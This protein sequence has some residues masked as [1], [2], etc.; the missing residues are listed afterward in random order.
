[1][2][3][4]ETHKGQ[5]EA[6]R[7][8][9]G[10]MP[11]PASGIPVPNLSQ[12]DGQRP[13]PVANPAERERRFRPFDVVCAKCDRA[14]HPRRGAEPFRKGP[15]KGGFLCPECFILDQDEHPDP[16]MSPAARGRLAEEAKKIR[17]EI[18]ITRGE[19][20]HE[21]DD[22]RAWM[23]PR[24]TIHLDLKRTPFSGPDEYDI[25]RF[26]ALLRAF[27]AVGKQC[28]GLGFEEAE[29]HKA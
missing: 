6:V 1:M 2:G 24:G 10:G 7:D 26:R 27:R 16:K 17:Q 3:E 11:P 15:Y 8:E 19:L 28:P 21:D 4:T 14:I 9:G 13:V 29:W 23:T 20:M 5:Q 22:V 25:W 12:V 18:A